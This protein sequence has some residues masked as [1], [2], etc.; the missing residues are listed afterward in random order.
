MAA[1]LLAFM[2]ILTVEDEFLIS[3]YLRT[4]LEAHGHKVVATFDADAA[5]GALEK[6]DDFQLVITD[7]NMPG[8]MDGLR[9]AAAIRRK[10]AADP[11]DSR[12]GVYTAEADRTAFGKLVCAET[13]RPEGYPYGGGTFPIAE[14]TFLS[15]SSNA[16]AEKLRNSGSDARPL[17]EAYR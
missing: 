1:N 10:V 15:S 17:I 11:S 12:H 9:L 3:E 5:I 6:T 7:I 13:L 2:V 14:T 16:L 8:A 4:I